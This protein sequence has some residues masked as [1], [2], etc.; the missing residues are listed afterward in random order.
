MNLAVVRHRL[1]LR[2]ESYS[3]F[4]ARSKDSQ[5]E[6]RESP[7]DV[8]TEY[9]RDRDRIV[10]SK[11]F[12]RLK[13]K[14]QVFIAPS[15]DHYVTRLTHTLEVSQIAR[16]IARAL[17]LNEDLAEAIALG[18]DLGHTPFGHVGEKEV[19]DL[20]PAG[21]THASQSLRIVEKLE[22]KGRGLNLT[23]DV[24]QGI[25]SH[26]KPRGDVMGGA[27][28][29]DLTLEAQIVR[30]S[31]AIAYLNHDLADAFRAGVLKSEDLPKVVTERLGDRHSKRIDSMVTDI[32]SASWDAAG[33]NGLDPR[34]S[35]RMSGEMRETVNVLREFMFER[36]YV[37]KDQGAEGVAARE[38]VRL[39]YRHFDDNRS[40]IP[41]EYHDEERAVVDYIAG[42]TDQYAIRMA[43]RIEP[44]IGK[45][46]A[47]RRV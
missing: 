28:P 8:R 25:A 40:T 19:D 22:R 36:F 5:R 30:L 45:V 31:D 12:R 43:E 39:L 7:S 18:H 10:H 35:I 41:G 24:R 11:A 47:M 27:V 42:M 20:H 44:G 1:E 13:H 3:P 9:Q 46:F 6:Q 38:I 17:N 2:E 14:T 26:S 37:P 33:E 16:T 32:V 29:G 23:F 15:G 4:A 34:P 21:F